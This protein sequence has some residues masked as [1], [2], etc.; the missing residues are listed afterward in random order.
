MQEG[1]TNALWEE[2]IRGAWPSYFGSYEAYLAAALQLEFILDF[3]SYVHINGAEPTITKFAE[4]IPRV[5]FNYLPDFWTNRLNPVVPIAEYLYDRLETDDEYPF[6][7]AIE[8]NVMNAFFANKSRE[9][10]LILLGGYL[11]QLEEWQ[12]K[13]MMQQ[14][15]FP[16]M[17][18][19]PEKLKAIVELY[20]L[21]RRTESPGNR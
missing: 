7:L 12:D 5:S 3:N 21:N 1:R 18:E 16:F 14:H 15:R 19:W 8:R 6:Y 2:R 13:V 17:F 9:Q 4:S 11:S 20:K 10:K